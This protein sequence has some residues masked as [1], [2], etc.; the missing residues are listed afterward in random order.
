MRK[1]QEYVDRIDE[2]IHDAKDYAESYVYYKAAGA[3]DKAKIYHD[4][5]ADELKH[6]TYIHDI[7]VKEIE[8]LNKVYKPTEEMEKV[9]T[10]SHIQYVDKVAW[11][12]TMLAM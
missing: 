6:A 3:T 9:W 5:S 8:M 12:K 2:E 11:I 1:I 7:A 4:M 10:T